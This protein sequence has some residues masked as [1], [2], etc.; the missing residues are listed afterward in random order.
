MNQ[1]IQGKTYPFLRLQLK[2]LIQLKFFSLLLPQSL[3]SVSYERRTIFGLKRKELPCI[4][5]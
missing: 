2:K 1:M 3:L 5:L 4:I